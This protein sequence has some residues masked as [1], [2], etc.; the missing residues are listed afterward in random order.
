MFLSLGR[1]LGGRVFVWNNR[2][3]VVDLMGFF[4]SFSFLLDYQTPVSAFLFIFYL[5]LPIT[6]LLRIV[7]VNHLAPLWFRIMPQRRR[8]LCGLYLCIMI[9]FYSLICLFYL[10]MVLKARVEFLYPV[11]SCLHTDQRRLCLLITTCS[12]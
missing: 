1:L 2:T 12:E 3:I 9:I 6:S 5:L 11:A 7:Y 4:G 8:N 10:P